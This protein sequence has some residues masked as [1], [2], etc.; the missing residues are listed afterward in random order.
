M[1]EQASH[2]PGRLT[3]LPIQ[4]RPIAGEGPKSFIERLAAA[5]HLKPG[6]LRTHLC[7]SRL[8]RGRPTWER[9]AAASGRE[10]A[11]LRE[12]LDAAQCPECGRPLLDT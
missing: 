5:N 10:P 1:R 11:N 12:I 4:I 2:A 7:E 9:L 6:H 8:H 3:T